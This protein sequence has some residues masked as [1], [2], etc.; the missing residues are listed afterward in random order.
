[1]ALFLG[2]EA[3][4]KHFL[5]RVKLY[6]NDLVSWNYVHFLDYATERILLQKVGAGYIF[7]H[8]LLKQYLAS[9]YETL[10]HS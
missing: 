8:P 10:E 6:N 1:M 7:I 2:G 3:S 9:L 5:L 4:I